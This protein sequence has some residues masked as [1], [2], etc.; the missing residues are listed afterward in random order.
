MS[1]S[2]RIH[3]KNKNNKIYDTRSQGER[4]LPLT[5]DAEKNLPQIHPITVMEIQLRSM[6]EFLSA[7]QNMEEM[8]KLW[9]Y[10][11]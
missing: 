5:S 3:Y 11:R 4:Q 2:G 1:K 6:Q 10:R 9:F 8:F 7:T